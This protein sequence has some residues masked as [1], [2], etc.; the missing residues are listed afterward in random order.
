MWGGLP[1]SSGNA[2]E[3]K[4]VDRLDLFLRLMHVLVR[5]ARDVYELIEIVQEYMK[6]R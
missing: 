4:E 6:G 1:I 2:D 5:L 3:M